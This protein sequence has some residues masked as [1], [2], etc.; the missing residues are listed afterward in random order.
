MTTV[1]ETLKLQKEPQNIVFQIIY[2]S[3]LA[4]IDCINLFNKFVVQMALVTCHMLTPRVSLTSS[5]TSPSPGYAGATRG[6]TLI[7]TS[8]FFIVYHKKTAVLIQVLLSSVSLG[9][10]FKLAD[11]LKYMYGRIYVCVCSGKNETKV[12]REDKLRMG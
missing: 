4:S 12:L 10:H 2:V 7:L 5:L 8:D 11:L 9:F 6:H 1:F 3:L